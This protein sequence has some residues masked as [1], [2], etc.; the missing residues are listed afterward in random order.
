MSATNNTFS[1]AADNTIGTLNGLFKQVYADQLKNLIP[2][3]VKLMNLLKWEGEETKLGDFFNCPVI[4][5]MEHGITFASSTED[6][7]NLAPP[8]AGT[9]QNAQ[10]RGYPAVLCSVLG[11]N[12]ASRSVSSTGAF[13][14]ATSYLVENMM[15]SMSKKLEIEMFY[16]QMG[17]GTV[18]SAGVTGANI[19]ITTAEWAPGI[20]S[21]C[22]NMPIQIRD[23]TGATVRGDFTCVSADLDTRVVTLN[24]SAQAAGVIAG[25]VV[26]HKGAYGN[27]FPGVHKILTTQSGTLFNISTTNYNLFRGNQ[28]SAQSGAL[29]FPKLS[30]AVARAVEKGLD[31]DIHFLVN[32]RTWSNL[33]ADEVALR[34]YDGSYSSVQLENGSKA[35]KFYS[36]NGTLIIEPSIYVKEGYAYGLALEDWKRVGSADMTF[37]VPGSGEEF[38]R[39]LES[40]AGYQLRLWTDQALFCSAP[41]RSVIVTAIVN[42]N[43]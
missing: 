31:T 22:N 17:Y 24:A 43:P 1:P 18:A 25:D 26:W 2:D 37:R 4:L 30:Q 39:H 35:L 32:N 15:R 11:Y 34:R 27:E 19:T 16:G 3:G 23:A 41:G 21:G 7:F 38:F 28:Y 5:G 9:I 14:K 20:W 12:A 6:A 29:S 40:A 8:V 33:L 13:K 42:T 10:V 36:Q